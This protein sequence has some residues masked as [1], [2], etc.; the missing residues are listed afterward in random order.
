MSE[1]RGQNQESLPTVT[2]NLQL[3]F[4]QLLVEAAILV[5]SFGV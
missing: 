5:R 4:A 3:T 2:M 1:A